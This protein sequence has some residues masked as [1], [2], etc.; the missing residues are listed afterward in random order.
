MKY[1]IH[2]IS[3]LV[4]VLG[5]KKPFSKDSEAALATPTTT[6][7]SS[8]SVVFIAGYDEDDN[9]YYTK[10]KAFFKE[11][12]MVL[13]DTLFSIDEIIRWLNQNS[14]DTIRYKEIHIVSHSNPWLGMS[15]KTIKNGER[16]TTTTLQK[17]K[18][19]QEIQ[20]LE[21]GISNETK[22]IFHSC[23]LGENQELLK[24]L[25]ETF[26]TKTKPYV[27]ASSYFNVFGGKNAP[28]YLAK[29]YY[30]FYP[31]AESPGPNALS[32]EYQEKYPNKAIDWKEA[33]RTREEAKA[34]EVYSYK[35]N[36]PVDWEFT[37]DNTADIPELKD[38]EAIMDWVSQSSEMT[39]TLYNLNIPLEKYRWKSKIREN[40]LIIKGKTTVFC[41]LEPI[42]ENEDTNEY[43]NLS[44]EDPF[45]YQIL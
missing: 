3:F 30:N 2:I 18:I 14:N 42:L 23:G 16:I 15:L 40:K 34:G 11:K 32:K 45:L 41:I 7:S 43:Y 33:M 19:N 39:E 36:I 27:Y 21:N 37:F 8:K 31:T 10:A 4:L 26:S 44:L 35:F 12:E 20:A 24:E 17:A 13:V 22:I 28:H 6:E 38:K 29:S 25:K 1:Y 5:C 9:A